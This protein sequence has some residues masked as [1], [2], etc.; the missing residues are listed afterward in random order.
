MLTGL[1]TPSSGTA[2]V[3]GLDIAR[4]P[5]EVKEHIGV[6]SDVAALYS[7]MSAW[8]NLTFV[9]RMH[10]M[11][12]ERGIGRAE[13]LLH[14]FGLHDMRHKRVGALSTGLKKR[15]TIAAALIHEPQILFL[16]EP[17]TGLDVQSARLIRDLMREL[18]SRGV[19]ILLTTHYIEEADQLCQRIAI[20]NRGKIIAVDT[21]ENLKNLA[22]RGKVIQASFNRP[23]NAMHSSLEKLDHVEEVIISGRKATLYVQDPSEILPFLVD[24]ARKN[25]LRVLSLNTLQPTLEDA[26]VT[27]TG[28]PPEAMTVEEQ[29]E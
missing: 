16:D 21:P 22:Q 28:L 9:A 12:R 3:A 19:T 25:H 15:L 7:E 18:N 24:M 17:T 26:F 29:L 13:E 20:L 4:R 11:S 8:D 23:V 6:V 5:V 2:T 14:L 1:T 10:G 27:L